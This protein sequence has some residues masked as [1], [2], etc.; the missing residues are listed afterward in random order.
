MFKFSQSN[1]LKITPA[2][3]VERDRRPLCRRLRSCRRGISPTA[4]DDVRPVLLTEAK[5]LRFL[6]LQMKVVKRI[7]E[8]M[9]RDL[10]RPY[11]A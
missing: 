1:K 6:S 8:K 10:H 2:Q 11:L 5:Q 4:S 9:Y 3:C 7:M